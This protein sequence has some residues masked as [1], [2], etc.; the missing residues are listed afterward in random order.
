MRDWYGAG[1][2]KIQKP[3]ILSGTLLHAHMRHG[4]ENSIGIERITSEGTNSEDSSD[5]EPAHHGLEDP[6]QPISI[7][8]SS[9]KEILDVPPTDIPV[10]EEHIFTSVSVKSS[11]QGGGDGPI[12][13]LE[14]QDQPS[15]ITPSTPMASKQVKFEKPESLKTGTLSLTQ[16]VSGLDDDRRPVL[17]HPV[18]ES[19]SLDEQPIVAPE[20]L[21]AQP[22]NLKEC[23][24]PT[25]SP[26]ATDS[27]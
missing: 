23:H 27:P 24:P 2:N 4:F 10:M 1:S 19:M 11:V 18:E 8:K 5:D 13:D 16:R 22:L 26:A 7:L 15:L 6:K 14:L 17:L 3:D 12:P 21:V 20:P 25:S 9:P